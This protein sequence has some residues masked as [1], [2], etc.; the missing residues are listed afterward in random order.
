MCSHMAGMGVTRT[1]GER[2]GQAA[3]WWCFGLSHGFMGVTIPTGLHNE[4]F[5]KED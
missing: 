1:G 3:C 4:E 5:K 2:A